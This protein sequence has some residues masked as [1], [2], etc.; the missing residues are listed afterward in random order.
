MP[1]LLHDMRAALRLRHYSPRTERSYVGWVRRY[2]RF[3]GL[4][5]PRTCGAPEIR[6]FLEHLATE[7]KVAAS[8][9]NQAHAA[10]LFLYRD[11]LRLPMDDT[12]VAVRAKEKTRVPNVLAPDEVAQVIEAL[13]GDVQLVTRL[14]YG[15]G[16]R[17]NEALELRI[18]DVDLRRGVLIVR[19]G[20]GAKDRRTV[21]PESV[22][23][24]LRRRILDS[25]T[26]HQ[27]DVARGGGSAYR[28][29]S[30]ASCRVRCATGGG[31]GSFLRLGSIATGRP[32]A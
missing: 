29:R 19:S 22:M 32:A 5:H 23:D 10:L 4:R 9:Q 13:R 31:R 27:R 25:R 3:C 7:R 18:K 26:L 20:K 15:S 12:R 24:D 1:P 8:T 11:V 30:P 17:L 16:L 28:T 21:L 2:V 6:S 14:L